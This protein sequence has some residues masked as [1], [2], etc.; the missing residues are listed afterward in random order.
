M[1]EAN[2]LEYELSYLKSAHVLSRVNKSWSYTTKLQMSGFS[3]IRI[4]QIVGITTSL[5]LSGK[6]LSPGPRCGLTQCH[7]AQS[8]HI[9]MAPYQPFLSHLLP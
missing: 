6:F 7:Q 2:Q 3:H 8:S 1:L 4:A 9:L 5:A